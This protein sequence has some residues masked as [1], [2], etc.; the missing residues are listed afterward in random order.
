MNRLLQVAGALV[1]LGGGL[2]AQE[3]S[4]DKINKELN[5]LFRKA[6][7]AGPDKKEIGALLDRALDV[8]TD[9]KT[10]EQGFNAYVFVA[11]VARYVD[12]KKQVELF[13]E[14]MDALIENFLNDDKMSQVVLGV[15]AHPEEAVKKKSQEYL[16][17]IERDTKSDGVKCALEYR[18]TESA[19]ASAIKPD[20]MKASIA[21]LQELKKKYGEKKGPDGAVWSKTIDE[22]IASVNDDLKLNGTAAK[23][24]SGEDLDGVAFKLA[25]YKGKAVLLDFWG[26]W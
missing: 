12:E 24:T 26:Y 15:L 19:A 8:A 18:R 17:W 1:L 13:T 2:R 10:D 14:S 23:E 5:D 7:E 4:L 25:D 6:K 20:A 3:D 21:K 16:E 9:H 22:A 11:Q